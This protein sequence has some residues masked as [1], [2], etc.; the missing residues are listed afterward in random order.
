M[1]R[2]GLIIHTGCTVNLDLI[3]DA[4]YTESQPYCLISRSCLAHIPAVSLS[5]NSSR[6]DQLHEKGDPL[7]RCRLTDTDRSQHGTHKTQPQLQRCIEHCLALFIR[8]HAL[9][10]QCNAYTVCVCVGGEEEE[11]KMI[12]KRNPTELLLDINS[13][14]MSTKNS[15]VHFSC[16]LY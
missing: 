2:L 3:C 13:A 6:T 8:R 7:Q 4:R 9:L 15:G 14:I 10:C 5:V 11:Q 12:C 16:S 1:L